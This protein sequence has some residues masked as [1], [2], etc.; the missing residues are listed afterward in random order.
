M[1]DQQGRASSPLQSSG[2]YEA[3]ASSLCA[4]ARGAGVRELHEAVR[5]VKRR[6]WGAAPAQTVAIRERPPASIV[7]PA[8]ALSSVA[9]RLLGR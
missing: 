1:A 4:R 9:L 8:P 2:C 7:A 3:S 5:G 6:T